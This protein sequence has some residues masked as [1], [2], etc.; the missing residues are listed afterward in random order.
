MIRDAL[1][2]FLEDCYGACGCDVK[3][4][5]VYPISNDESPLAVNLNTIKVAGRL[6]RNQCLFLGGYIDGIEMSEDIG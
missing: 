6:R 5:P 1:L 3:Q 4:L 2:I